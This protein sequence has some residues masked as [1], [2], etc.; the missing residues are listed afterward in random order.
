MSRSP[1]TDLAPVCQLSCQVRRPALCLAAQVSTLL[2]SDVS[3]LCQMQGHPR[4]QEKP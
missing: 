2:R 4:A 1:Q 3:I